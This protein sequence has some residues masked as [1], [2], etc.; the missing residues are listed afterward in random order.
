M[1]FGVQQDAFLQAPRLLCTGDFHLPNEKL[2]NLA[3]CITYPFP[4][5][6]EKSYGTAESCGLAVAPLHRRSKDALRLSP[7]TRIT[8]LRF[9]TDGTSA[10]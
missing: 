2:P 8:T 4:K 3:I 9:A 10:S 5:A 6:Q 7:T 1:R